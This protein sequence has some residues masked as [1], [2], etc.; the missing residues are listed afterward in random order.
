MKK[1]VQDTAFMIAH[2]RAQHESVSK[3][4]YAKLWLT[5][6]DLKPWADDFEA[7]VSE[8]D[9]LLH[10]LRNRYFY[11][12][13]TQL[14]KE[15]PETL[16]VNL[17]AGFSMYPYVLP[18]ET[19]SIE[20]ELPQIASYKADKIKAFT[21]T[22]TLPPRNVLHI[23]KNITDEKQHSDIID[24]VSRHKKNKTAL[25]IEGVFFFL[26]EKEIA[27]VINLCKQIQGPGDVLLCV[28]FE[29]AL[30]NTEVFKRLKTYF[31]EVLDTHGNPF[32]TLSHSYFKEV[33]GYDLK[34][35]SST[36][37]L[38]KEL[39]CFPKDFNDTLVLDEQL[40]HLIRR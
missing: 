39:S 25:L 22:G 26:N 30:A 35:R 14:T 15:E 17:G 16:I 2:Y 40:Y 21:D 29:Q 12:T 32:T 18:K 8:H 20:I 31:T 11:N 34:T 37:R 9:E 36:L 19:T 24:L 10:C 13:L 1:E 23:A 33:D 4:P 28:S 27:S 3:D 38:G 5:D 7:E 6:T